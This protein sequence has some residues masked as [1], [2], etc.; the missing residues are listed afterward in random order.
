MINIRRTI[1]SRLIRYGV[2]GGMSALLDFLTFAFLF[3]VLHINPLVATAI[4]TSLGIANSFILNARYNFRVH[5]KL[6]KRFA[7][8]YFVGLAGLLFSVVIIYVLHARIGIDANLAKIISIPIVVLIQYALNSR[9]SLG[10]NPDKELRDILGTVNRHKYELLIIMLSGIC[11]LLASWNQQNI[12]ETDNM[13]GGKLIAHG[14]LPYT[15]FFSH[16]MPGMYYYGYLIYELSGNNI[17]DFRL[18]HNFVLFAFLLLICLVIKRLVSKPVAITYL[19][20]A[21]VVH[22]IGNGQLTVAE[23]FVY[24]LLEL[25]FVLIF[26]R[27]E[28]VFSLRKTAGIS[29]ALFFVPFLSL[30]YIFPALVLYIALL[31]VTFRSAPSRRLLRTLGSQVAIFVAPYVILLIY[32]AASGALHTFIYNLFTFNSKYYAPMSGEQ[33]GDPL[34]TLLS[35]SANSINQLHDLVGNIFSPDQLS[36]FLLAFGFVFL[37]YELWRRKRT[38]EMYLLAPLFL[39]LDPRVNKFHPPAMTTDFGNLTHHGMLYINFAVLAGAIG[40]VSFIQRNHDKHKDLVT[41]SLKIA[42]VLYVLVVPV[43]LLQNWSDHMNH[44]FVTKDWKTFH[45]SANEEAA[46][47]IATP[48]N[49]LLSPTQKAWIGPD[50]LVSQLYLK[51]ARATHF[52]FYFPWFDSSP[53][54][55]NEFISQLRT[56]KPEII[57][58][59][60]YSDYRYSAELRAVLADNY[61]TVSDKRLQYYYFLD[62]DRIQLSHSLKEQG[63]AA[64]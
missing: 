22:I 16:H 2:F 6:L 47:N 57:Y 15:G 42:V 30:G 25:V 5:D 24:L 60:T 21:S 13:L 38:L 20:A 18:I 64:D 33:G 53:K 19:I 58:F 52:Y 10:E 56:D 44:L 28:D 35:I 4:S 36:H 39:L 3:N 49:K 55:R 34:K 8:F 54:V 23:S 32:L 37:G 61:F 59:S 7:L 11:F 62:Q 14:S 17:F 50:D 31:L 48:I 29:L 46:N 43:S 41:N 9:Y 51:P 45:V 1:R 40:L 63:Y 27:R 26:F 12:D